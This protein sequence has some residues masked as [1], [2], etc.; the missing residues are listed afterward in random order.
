MKSSFSR[1]SAERLEHLAELH[2]PALAPGPPLLAVEAVAR[3]EQA[4]R[5]GGSLEALAAGGS[6]PQTRS[7]S[8]QGSAIETP[9]PRSIV[10]RESA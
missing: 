10:R 2:G 1:K 3:E 8:S 5:T 7:D 6:S 4:N 9:R